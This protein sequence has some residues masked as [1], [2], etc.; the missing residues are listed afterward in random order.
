MSFRF[1]CFT[2]I[3]TDITKIAQIR[4]YAYHIRFRFPETNV[5]R[6]VHLYSCPIEYFEPH[7]FHIQFLKGNLFRF[8]VGIGLLLRNVWLSIPIPLKRNFD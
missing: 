6:R 3:F 2:Y 5:S 7:E 4:I 1:S 8:V